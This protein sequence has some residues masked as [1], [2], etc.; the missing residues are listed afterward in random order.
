MLLSPANRTITDTDTLSFTWGG[1][2]NAAGYL[3]NLDDVVVDVDDTSYVTGPLAAGSYTWT[4]AAYDSAGNTGPFARVWAL[5]I[6][7]A[8]LIH[9]IPSVSDGQVYT[10]GTGICGS[11]TFTSTGDVSRVTITY[12]HRY[13]SINGNGLPRQYDIAIAGSTFEAKL[14]LCY[15]DADLLVAGIDPRVEGQLH[16]YRYV[17]GSQPWQK[18]SE[19]DTANNTVTV[20]DAEPG[21]WGLGVAADY[22][23]TITL[24]ASAAMPAGKWA[25][26]LGML[27]GVGLCLLAGAWY[28]RRRARRCF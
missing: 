17:G 21:V 26:W 22:P 27:V 24:Q 13:P 20:Y 8:P 18:Y 28:V 1:V 19:V 15:E 14:V 16:A 25:V 11:I 4:V 5:A 7:G 3:L 6:S 2:I 10:F 23:T 9:T 12:T